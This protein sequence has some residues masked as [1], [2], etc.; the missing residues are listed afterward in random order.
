MGLGE[1]VAR[2]LVREIDP[3]QSTCCR[4]PGWWTWRWWGVG[5]QGPGGC[6]ATALAW[7]I[8]LDCC[9]GSTGSWK[10]YGRGESC[11]PGDAPAG[12]DRGESNAD[13]GDGSGLG[14]STWG[15]PTTGMRTGWECWTRMGGTSTRCRW[16][17][18]LALYLLEVRGER[19]PIVK[20]ITSSDMLFRLGEL[21]DVPVLE[22]GVGFK[23]AG[24]VDD[25]GEC[26]DGG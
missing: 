11:V 17:A 21:Y 20:S 18:L 22:T 16:F 13:V 4:W 8:C 14:D 7:G 6:D 2:E 10:R 5:Y 15:L 23:Y 26:I 25:E 3:V 1:A 12:A 24:P 19:G 9:R